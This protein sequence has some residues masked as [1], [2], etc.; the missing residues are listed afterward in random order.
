MVIGTSQFFFSQSITVDTSTYTISQLVNSVLINSPCVNASNISS[1]TGTNFGSSNG[2]GYFTNTN[3]NFPIQSG[4]ILSTGNV[5]NAVGPNTTL[6]NDGSSA[7][8]GDTTL[9]N[10]LIQAGINMTSVNA[11]VLEFDFTPISSQFSFDFVFASEEYGNFQCQFSDAFAFIITNLNTGDSKNLAVIPNTTTPI[12]VVT[13][14]D[15][16][17]NSSCGSANSSYFG[18]YNGG[19]AS[20]ASPTNFNGQTVL[21]HAHDTL[22]ANTPYH[23]KL[24]IADRNDPLSDSAIFL[25]SNSLNI[26]QDVLG[27][28]LT[29]QEHTAICYS[30]N[31]VIN[32]NLNPS[33]YSFL[34]KKNGVVLPNES[35]ATLTINSPG[36]YSVTYNK[37]VLP[38]QAFTDT[39]H[40]EYYPK[41]NYPDPIN[42]TKCNTGA[43]SY[44]FD[45]EL[46]TPIVKNGLQYMNV[47]YFASISNLLNLTNP[48]TSPYSSTG[49]KL[50][51]VLVTNTLTN[52]S[53]YRYFYLYVTPPPVI[54]QPQNL[55][56]CETDFTNHKA[57]FNLAAQ[58]TLVLNGLNN[59]LYTVSFYQNQNDAV[60][61]TNPVSTNYAA[62]NGTVVYVRVTNNG[63]QNCFS[64]TNFQLFVNPRP[65]VDNLP[66]VIK[67]GSYTLPVLQNGNYYTEPNGAG[68]LLQAGQSVNQSCTMYVYNTNTFCNNQSSF[69]IVIINIASILPINS[70]HCDNYSLPSLSYGQYF[71]Q[72]NRQGTQLHANDII[73]NTQ[74]IYVN[75]TSTTGTPCSQEGSF[76]ITIINSP[77]IPSFSNTTV[78]T[79]YVLPSLN[80]GN[81]FTGPIGSG[82]NLPFGTSIT[83]TQTIYVYA[84][85]DTTPNCWTQ[86]SFKVNVG[87]APIANV[88]DC[89]KYK[90]PPLTIGN[91]YTGPNGTGNLLTAGN[92]I[93]TS[94]DLHV[95]A[96]F[97]DGCTLDV[98]FS[99]T[100]YLPLIPPVTS[101]SQCQSYTLPPITVGNYFTATQGGGMLLNAGTEITT[102]QRVYIYLNNNGCISETSFM[103][104]IIPYPNIDSRSNIDVCNSYTLTP[105]TIGNYYT[106][107][108][109]SGTLLPANS[110]V[111]NTQTIFIYAANSI[112]NFVC[113]SQNSF[114]IYVQPVL[115]DAPQNVQACDSYTLPPLLNGQYY[116]ELDGPHGSGIN[117]VAGTVITATQTLFVFNE[118]G[119]RINCTL[120]NPFTITIN[121]TPNISQSQN[122]STCQNYVLPVLNTGNYYTQPNGLGTLLQTGTIITNNQTLFVFAETNTSPNCTVQNSFTISL[123]KVTVLQNVTSCFSYTL[124]VLNSGNY[125]TG[126][127]G[128]GDQLQA[129][130]IVTTSQTIFIYG[131][132]NNCN[133]QSSFNITIN[134]AVADS[135]PNQSIC[136]SY[137][138]P[139]LANGNYYTQNFGGGSLLQS[140]NAITTSQ[141]LYIY[142]ASSVDSSCFVEHSFTVTI[143]YTP[144]I[145]KF[146]NT[147]SCQNY[148][149]APL[150]LGNYYTQNNGLGTLLHAGDV[151]N[152]SQILYVFAQTGTTPN[153]ASESNFNV[154]IINTIADEPNSISACDSYTLPALTNGNYYTGSHATGTLLQSGSVITAT[155][156]LYVYNVST[157]NSNC[158]AEHSFTI[159]IN[160]TPILPTT[161]NITT[162]QSY[163]LPSL[164][165][166]NYYT[167]SNGQ[168]GLLYSGDVLA[169]DHLIYIYAQ[170]GTTPNCTAQNSFTVSIHR[171]VVLPNVTS[172]NNFT[173]PILNYGSYYTASNGS[174][175]QLIAGSIVSTSQMMYIYNSIGSC[176]DQSSFT[177]TINSL[178]ADEPSNQVVCDSYS[179]PVLTNGN[180]YT[181]SHGGGNLL[182]SGN[183]ITSTQAL[184]VYNVSPTDSNCFAEHTFN[185][186]VN[187]T[188]ILPIAQNTIACQSYTLPTLAIG[189]YFTQSNGLGTSLHAG[190]VIN[191]NQTVYV[192]AQT[193]T[194][195]NCTA[196]NN[197][198]ITLYKAAVLPNVTT[199]NT[200]SLTELT[201]GHYYT[202]PNGTGSQLMAGTI[203]TTSQT[204]YIYNSFENCQDQSSFTITINPLAVDTLSNQQVCDSYTLP[205]LNHGNYYTQ[206]LGGG[207]LLHSGNG[208]ATTQTLYIYNVSPT[209]SNCFAEHTFTVTVKQ[210][211]VLPNI[212]NV[213]T[214]QSYTLPT[215]ALGNYFTQSNGLGTVLQAG[216]VISTNQTLYVFAQTGNTPNCISETKF[217]V[218]L[219]KVDVLPNVTSC[220]A[221]TLPSLN[222]GHYFTGLNG[223]GNQLAIGSTISSN[224]TIY[225]YGNLN[226]CHDQSSF[227]VSFNS[228]PNVNSVPIKKRSICDTDGVN[229]GIT[230]F[231]LT[232]LTPYVLGN[233]NANDYTVAYY[234]NN[235]NAIGQTNE[236]TT[237]IS[238]IV[239]ARVNNKTSDSCFDIKPI[240]ILVN[241]LPEPKL[242]NGVLCLDPTSSTNTPHIIT[243]GLNTAYHTYSWSD[244]DGTVISSATQLSVT[245]PGNYSVIAT[246]I[247]TNCCSIPV[248]TNV[249]QSQIPTVTCTVSDAFSEYQSITVA[250]TGEGDYEYQLDNEN[251]QNNPVFDNVGMG[252][253]SVTVQDK[254]GCGSIVKEVIVVNYPKFFTPNADGYNDTWSVKGI[255][256]ASVAI[257]DKFGKLITILDKANTSWDGTF[258]GEMAPSDDYWFVI[259]YGENGN[260]KEFKAHFALKR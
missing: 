238:N 86:K 89:Q 80:V 241:K 35:G 30:S 83:Q 66:N 17:Y 116:T 62:T 103:V 23:V 221:F 88:Y 156:T 131:S 256:I 106:G 51:Y 40:I 144:I 212:Q 9:D 206:S 129:G 135:L 97:A 34:W 240:S 112:G 139:A 70:S 99:V 125:Y 195:P 255:N 215:L 243:T 13:I 260:F 134:T 174:G 232:N 197:F 118:S 2:I 27:L 158:Y 259:K 236:L 209:D 7:W 183:V 130:A 14:R 78:C 172:C 123:Y 253:H 15:L 178:V 208:I 152:T 254:N 71:T 109:G 257:F 171:A 186:T 162:C 100:I 164:T 226:S 110:S 147:T 133:D 48:I 24:V 55:T 20:L 207:T 201:N 176:H 225:I 61:K 151:I 33:Q 6:S 96:Q 11:T 153:C 39:V 203:I 74:T 237:T 67:C 137:I 251:F 92:Y 148:V 87:I 163:V 229:D 190:D 132:L 69:T 104:T 220:S 218:S 196:E 114:S 169:N 94:Q 76:T 121:H 175:T 242:A 81:Y 47:Q 194:I 119:E 102:T 60:T 85:T 108:N 159:T 21:M 154:T 192:F 231:D 124:P 36:D 222:T 258:N 239:Y 224:Q 29:V 188:P 149:L 63:D 143:N 75:Y 28:D 250:A 173:L 98:P 214:C 199:C 140:G 79:E 230:N 31:Y 77:S 41:I 184:Y 44:L 198:T 136:D 128:T 141:T 127:N 167:G 93:S 217:T 72:P 107:I 10:T 52:C 247:N 180:Y 115:A 42:L 12:S 219:Y 228:K 235:S 73:T 45:L 145:P 3:P 58:N 90:L 170:T 82:T 187:Q 181:Q 46:N 157:V 168:G 126:P 165:V 65:I 95:F 210:T 4:V 200:Y 38:C 91:Y 216:E 182:Q 160:Q 22:E 18:S 185:V 211:P 189:N 223:T 57:T 138:L 213:V 56:L 59:T 25:S 249:I 204:I 32:S 117:L 205:P 5:A 1:S 245:N 105:L 53:A 166:G 248:T 177:I 252:I 43:T 142:N 68:T 19:S 161:P 233:Q 122:I 84:T 113:S 227:T 155:Q 193:G 179:L 150:T 191:N 49:N 37:L 244:Q 101:I 64:I 246:N 111:T 16:L 8:P 54:G 26:G 50:I 146:Q 234:L 202:A 120:N